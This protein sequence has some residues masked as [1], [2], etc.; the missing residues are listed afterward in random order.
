MV[1]RLSLIF[2]YGISETVTWPSRA[3]DALRERLAPVTIRPRRRARGHEIVSSRPGVFSKPSSINLRR[4]EPHV[5]SG[6]RNGVA[7]DTVF[8][9]AA[10]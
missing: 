7:I 4:F 1:T 8:P 3:T 6:S 10:P 5:K 9:G 2:E